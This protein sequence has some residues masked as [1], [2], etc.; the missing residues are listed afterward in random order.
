MGHDGAPGIK[1]QKKEKGERGDF[2]SSIENVPVKDCVFNKIEYLQTFQIPENVKGEFFLLM[3][4][5][6]QEETEKKFTIFIKHL[7][8]NSNTVTEHRFNTKN[9]YEFVKN[10]TLDRNVDLLGTVYNRSYFSRYKI[11]RKFAKYN[12]ETNKL[13]SGNVTAD[14]FKTSVFISVVFFFPD[15][16][17]L[18]AMYETHHSDSKTYYHL[19]KID[20]RNL[21]IVFSKSVNF[22]ECSIVNVVI[23]F[24]RI[25]CVNIKEQKIDLLPDIH[26]RKSP[27]IT[28]NLSA[29][30]LDLERNLVFYNYKSRH[31]YVYD[32]FIFNRYKLHCSKK[33]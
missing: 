1:G 17:Y 6:V 30:N 11:K 23:T 4:D 32:Q 14:L 8:T 33:D 20:P 31:L 3:I 22:S 5:P 13:T 18:W 29:T 9:E 19:L 16:N 26:E 7:S 25:Y 24:G 15:E 12:F 2:E 10:Y 27:K 28:L 21:E